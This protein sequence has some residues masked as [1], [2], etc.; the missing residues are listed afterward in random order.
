M[1]GNSEFLKELW[2]FE[3]LALRCGDV[4]RDLFRKPPAAPEKILV[5]GYAAIGDAMFLLPALEALRKAYPKAHMTFLA[6]RNAVTLEL[7]PAT[8]LF[9]EVELVEWWEGKTWDDRDRVTAKLRAAKFDAVVVT[10]ATPVHYFQK[11]IAK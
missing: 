6:N 3:A 5:I 2:A 4:R 7:I 8:G 11:A 9:N 1:K 10:L